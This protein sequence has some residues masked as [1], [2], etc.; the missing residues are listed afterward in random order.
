MYFLAMF[1]EFVESPITSFLVIPANPGSVPGQAPESRFFEHLQ[2]VW[3]PV[4]TGVTT[5][6]KPIKVHNEKIDL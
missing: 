5:F 1:D 2:N 6:Y 3:T 4:F